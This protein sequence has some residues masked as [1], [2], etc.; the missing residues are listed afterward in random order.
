MK[1]NIYSK[2]NDN[3]IPYACHYNKDTI[4][5]KNGN[6]CQ[7]LKITGFEFELVGKEKKDLRTSIREIIK[8]HIKDDHFAVYLHT[9]RR[10]KNLGFVY[11]SD[12]YFCNYLNDGWNK[13]HNWQNKYVNELYITIITKENTYSLKKL[14]NFLLS[15]SFF[16]LKL[17]ERSFL[18]KTCKKLTELVDDI[19]K[20][21]ANFG[22][23]KLI[24]AKRDLVKGEIEKD[25][26]KDIY[27]SEPLRFFNK[28]LNLEDKNFPI[29]EEDLSTQICYS[30]IVFGNNVFKITNDKK[31]HFG[32]ILSIKE[33]NDLPLILLDKFFNAP[34]ELIVTQS[35]DFVNSDKIEELYKEQKKI[36]EASKDYKFAENIGL[37]F[38]DKEGKKNI[39]DYGEQQLTIMLFASDKEKLEKI[40]EKSAKTLMNNGLVV[41][42]EDIF[43]EHCY[44][45]QLPGNFFYLKRK[46]YH[47]VSTFAGFASLQN[48][49]AGK[50]NNNKWG[51]A[52]TVFYTKNKTPYF[53]N[54]H[55]KGNGHSLI[56]GNYGTGKTVL[57]NFLIAQAQKFKNK[58]YYFDFSNSSKI[59]INALSGKYYDFSLEE[60][61]FNPCSLLKKKDFFIQ[62]I[63][64]LI[65]EKED[66]IKGQHKI[67]EKKEEFLK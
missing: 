39:N 18:K 21:L 57:L 33:Y 22:A 56:V 65:I 20:S 2:I 1:K 10:K 58:L 62:F 45:S 41:V 66:F 12:N 25:S 34:I 64:V 8:E 61:L 15:L 40:I 48:Y 17:K 44:F 55:Y 37:G 9:I 47:L 19:N 51:D 53:F 24:I 23:K 7:T 3:F 16:T 54:F 14:S 46:N 36:I 30:N 13:L 11:Q 42:R 60:K 52:V 26:K 28:I 31:K 59:F 50:K 49:P 35:L 43:M 63:S 4:L 5:T 6:L 27:Y 38:L 29:K 32:A 67:A